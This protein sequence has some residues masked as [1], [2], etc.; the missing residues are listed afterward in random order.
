MVEEKVYYADVGE[1]SQRQTLLVEPN[2]VRTLSLV[3]IGGG[4]KRGEP[5]AAVRRSKVQKE[6]DNQD[7]WIICRRTSRGR[8]P[9]PWVGEFRVEGGGCQSYPITDGTERCWEKNPEARSALIMLDIGTSAA[10]L[11]FETQQCHLIWVFL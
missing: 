6:A 3:G 2:V 11:E 4:E 5:G 9:S 10:C 1:H 7:V 8:Q